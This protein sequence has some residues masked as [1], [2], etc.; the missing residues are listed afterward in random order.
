MDWMTML[1]GKLT[2]FVGSEQWKE[3]IVWLDS[4]VEDQSR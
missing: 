1:R 2:R 3:D 4:Q